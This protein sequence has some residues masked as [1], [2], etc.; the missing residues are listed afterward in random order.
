MLEDPENEAHVI[1]KYIS[2]KIYHYHTSDW[3]HVMLILHSN[4]TVNQDSVR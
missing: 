4:F 2:V 1:F 3:R